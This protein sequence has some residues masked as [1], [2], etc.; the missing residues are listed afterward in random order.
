MSA[1]GVWGFL[2]Q[3]HIGS[4]KACLGCPPR[5]FSL[6]MLGWQG[7][8]EGYEGHR[9]RTAV[10]PPTVPPASPDLPCTPPSNP[11]PLCTSLCLSCLSYLLHSPLPCPL[12][13]LPAGPG[14]FSFHYSPGKLRGNQYRKMLAREELE[15]EQR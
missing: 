10:I 3:I 11:A 9:D 7:R 4:Q 6:R 2:L 12:C 1:L 8:L 15:E 5:G 13:S 14:C